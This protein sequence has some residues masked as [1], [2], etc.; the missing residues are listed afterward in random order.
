MDEAGDIQTLIQRHG[1]ALVLYA[2][3]FVAVHADAE[4]AVQNAFVRYWP[5]RQGAHDTVAFLFACVRTAAL[6][7]ARTQRRNRQREQNIRREEAFAID[8]SAEAAELQRLMSWQLDQLPAEQREV[9]VMKIWGGLT[10]DQIA[11]VLAISANTAAS[12]YRYGLEKLAAAWPSE[13]RNDRP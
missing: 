9:V 1:R 3:Q 7:L 10:F 2:R 11:A 13:V 6:D 8:T 4:D 12:R 5:R